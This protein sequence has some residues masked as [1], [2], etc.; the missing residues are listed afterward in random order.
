MINNYPVG[1]Q[2]QKR[3]QI[4]FY[5]YKIHSKI[6][7]IQRVTIMIVSMSYKSLSFHAI[8]FHLLCLLIFPDSLGRFFDISISLAFLPHT[9]TNSSVFLNSILQ[10][11]SELHEITLIRTHNCNITIY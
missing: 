3:T 1:A 10:N 2:N 7:S 5:L 8:F 6:L 11:I 4:A 9:Y